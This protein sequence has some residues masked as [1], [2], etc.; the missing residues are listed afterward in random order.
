MYIEEL[1]GNMKLLLLI[2]IFVIAFTYKPD[3]IPVGDWVALINW[4]MA[5]LKITAKWWL[6]M[7]IPYLYLSAL[8]NKY[9]D[10]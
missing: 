5:V 6:A 9:K 4:L 7:L 3:L 10:K 8:V 1:G 2:Y